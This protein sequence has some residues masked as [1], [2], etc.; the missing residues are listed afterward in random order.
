MMQYQI[1]W[2]EFNNPTFLYYR[3]RL[4]RNNKLY[5]WEG[6]IHEVITTMGKIIYSDVIITHKKIHET[7]PNRNINI[8]EKIINSGKEL[9]LRHQFYYARELFYHERYE[10]AIK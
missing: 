9:S 10:E 3:E 1:A 5:L 4:I 8:F 2:D 7:D 6:E